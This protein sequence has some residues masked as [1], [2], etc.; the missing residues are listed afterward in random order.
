MSD[1]F[2]FHDRIGRTRI[3]KRIAELNG[4]C[5]KEL[6]KMP[7]VKLH[8]PLDPSLSAGIICFEVIGLTTEAVV[9][10]LLERNIVSSASPYAKS[11]ARL[12][13]GIMNTPEEADVTLRAVRD[14]A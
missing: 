7:H 6:V 5:K 4:A 2:R 3:A 14:L 8:T 10:K 9:D 1:A 11:Y 13:F 12:S